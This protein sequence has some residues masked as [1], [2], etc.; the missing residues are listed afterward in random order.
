MKPLLAGRLRLEPLTRQ[1]AQAL[2]PLLADPRLYAYMDHGPPASEH[3]LADLYGRLEARQSPDG[4][5]QWLNWAVFTEDQRAVG[6]VQATLFSEHRAWIAYVL[7][8][9]HWGQGHG[10]LSTGAMVGHLASDCGVQQFL[11]C[12]ERA[13]IRS[14]SL[15]QH[16]GFDVAGPEITAA[17]T[18]TASEVLLVRSAARSVTTASTLSKQQILE[19]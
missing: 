3:A 6:F 13:N 18:L 12:V 7:G 17:H 11:A 9:A 5:E 4:A 8:S 15:L 16:L 14:L 1:H 2:Y 19:N 10:R